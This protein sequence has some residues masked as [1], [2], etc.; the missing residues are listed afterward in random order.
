MSKHEP[1]H[2]ETVAKRWI[3][4]PVGERFFVSPAGKMGITEDGF[5]KVEPL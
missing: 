5:G 3:L 4:L 1:C 2:S